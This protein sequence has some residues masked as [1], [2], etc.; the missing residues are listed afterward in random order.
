MNISLKT[1]GKNGVI[2]KNEYLN[3]IKL[4]H[5]TFKKLTVRIFVHSDR[6]SFHKYTWKNS[7]E[8]TQNDIC[9]VLGGYCTGFF[10]HD[11]NSIHIFEW[12]EDK[13]EY[14]LYVLYHELRHAW[15]L[16]YKPKILKNPEGVYYTCGMKW[17]IQPQELDAINFADKIIEKNK[18]SLS[19]I[20]KTPINYDDR[21][22]LFYDRHK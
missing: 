14:L 18:I 17:L 9:L 6:E 1:I 13:I 19:K 5:D 3:A 4:L 7:H 10:K 20:F 12:T 11:K 16:K 21:L 15:Q 22:R 8:L 2:K